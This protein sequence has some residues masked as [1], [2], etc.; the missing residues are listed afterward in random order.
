MRVYRL[1]SK[2]HQA[3]A[4]KGEGA[5]LAG[6]RWNHKGKRVVYCSE[7]RALAAM[8]SFVNLDPSL[9]PPELVFIAVD[10]PDTLIT[11]VKIADLPANWRDYPAPD[12]V[13]DIGTD[14]IAKQ[15]S[16]ALVVPSVVMPDERNVVLNPEHTDFGRIK[17]VSIGRSHCEQQC[18]R[19]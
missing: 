11:A 15:T 6:G 2:A 13:K 16:A 19:P 8:E 3:T 7:S 4:F 17:I 5:R 18:R 14:W 10:V 1:S 12:A 9:A